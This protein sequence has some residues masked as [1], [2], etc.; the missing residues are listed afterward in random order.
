MSGIW[1]FVFWVLIGSILGASFGA[2]G[3]VFGG[4]LGYVLAAVVSLRGELQKLRSRLDILEGQETEREP[5]T[6]AQPNEPSWHTPPVSENTSVIPEIPVLLAPQ[7]G[8]P[9][10]DLSGGPSDPIP[11]FEESKQPDLPV[12]SVEPRG[13]TPS[14][15]SWFVRFFMGDGSLVRVGVVLLLFGLGFL[16]KYTADLGF[17][18]IQWRLVSVAG[19]GFGLLALGWRLNK[20]RPLYSA[21]LQGGALGILNL[22]LYV[23]YAFYGFVPPQLALLGL[24]VLSGVALVLSVMGRTQVLAILGILGGFLAPALTSPG[25]ADGSSGVL[26]LFG[27]YALLDL[28]ILGIAF[29]RSWPGLNFLGF[30]FTFSIVYAVI[31]KSGQDT[32]NFWQ[33][34]SFLIFFYLL[35]TLLPSLDASKR[36]PGWVSYTLV[37]GVPGLTLLIQRALT[38]ETNVLQYTSLG[39]ACT[40]AVFWWR[41]RLSKETFALSQ[42]HL[43][44]AVGFSALTVF[45]WAKE[46]WVAA[47]VWALEASL[48]VW[49]GLR[50]SN[51]VLRYSGLVILGLSFA[52]AVPWMD[53]SDVYLYLLAQPITLSS[54]WVFGV[55]IWSG[56]GYHVYGARDKSLLR[57][58]FG[59]FLAIWGMAWWLIY[60]GM[61]IIVSH[62]NLLSNFPSDGPWIPF[63]YGLLYLTFS[64]LLFFAIGERIR[65]KTLCCSFGALLPVGMVYAFMNGAIWDFHEPN[66]INP[67]AW[68]VFF[69]VQ[70]GILHRVRNTSAAWQTYWHIGSTLLL[71]YIVGDGL[72]RLIGINAGVWSA[73]IWGFLPTLFVGVIVAALR[74][75]SLKVHEPTY[76]LVAQILAALGIFWLFGTFNQLESQWMYIPDSTSFTLAYVPLLNPFDIAQMVSLGLFYVLLVRPERQRLPFFQS[77]SVP[78][79]KRT[80]MRIWIALGLWVWTSVIVRAVHAWTGV[81]FE[82]DALLNSTHLQ[83]ALSISWMLAACTMMFY[84]SRRGRR[85]YWMIGAMLIAAVILKLFLVDLSG[86]ETLARVISFVGVGLFCLLISY[87]SPIPPKEDR[88]TAFGE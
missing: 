49:I 26:P 52:M 46:P 87:V 84:A 73:S 4:V 80:G 44:L 3:W 24:V 20:G 55:W 64:C 12:L 51:K 8:P 33:I 53:P 42:S 79:S 67:I 74:H 10:L 88:E 59:S 19:L 66:P 34:E 61:Y 71:F 48:L 63:S 9:F 31:G 58:R 18:S 17:F 35:Y 56:Y 41:F 21:A 16:V 23:A 11:G 40:Q 68:I 75:P 22:D 57:Q 60:G 54:L 72:T 70:Y 32:L 13:L 36:R 1:P 14:P 78:W 85:E 76:R 39:I 37:L 77:L 65:F 69:L 82:I 83:A 15:L 25:R 38:S 81:P 28:A 50:D 86:Q 6:I 5:Q 30:A 43:G 47:C 29:Y 27:Y 7:S 2:Y 62:S 45:L